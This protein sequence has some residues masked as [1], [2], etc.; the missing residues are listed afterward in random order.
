VFSCNVS[1]VLCWFLLFVWATMLWFSDSDSVYLLCNILFFGHHS[2][3][4]WKQHISTVDLSP[5]LKALNNSRLYI[6]EWTRVIATMYRVLFTISK[7]PITYYIAI[8]TWNNSTVS[9]NTA[10]L[11]F[12]MGNLI[13]DLPDA[14][15]NNGNSEVR[16]GYHGNW[17]TNGNKTFQ[18]QLC[19]SL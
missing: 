18:R 16:K 10:L 2:N 3:L 5:K 13:S 6:K 19:R 7:F 15:E 4:Y 17:N 11:M 1:V 8:N 14:P 9:I 12:P